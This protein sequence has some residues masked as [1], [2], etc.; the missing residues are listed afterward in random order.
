MENN[1]TSIKFLMRL[2]QRICNENLSKQDCI[3]SGIVDQVNSDGTVNVHIP[4]DNVIFTGIPNQC[5]FGLNPGDTV[6]LIKER[7]RASNMWVIA[8]CGESYVDVEQ[9]SDDYLE[10]EVISLGNSKQDK[11]TAGTGISIVNNVISAT[12]GGGAQ[13]QLYSPIITGGFNQ[14]SWANN[15]SNGDFDVTIV[16]DA[17]GQPVTSPLSITPDMSGEIL[18]VV[19]SSNNFRSAIEQVELEYMSANSLVSMTNYSGSE[20]Q[21]C[22]GFYIYPSTTVADYCT[23]LAD[24]S[25]Y[26]SIGTVEGLQKRWFYQYIDIGNNNLDTKITFNEP[27]TIEQLSFKI[28]ARPYD[29]TPPCFERPG[30]TSTHDVSTAISTLSISWL[31]NGD[32][33]AEKQTTAPTT[34]PFQVLIQLQPQDYISVQTGDELTFVVNVTY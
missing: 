12:G 13:P 19:A 20:T 14:I 25:N 30:A 32:V 17:N 29:G 22:L 23:V 1:N 7:G 4:P 16:A 28:V 21:A 9:S 3:T 10:Q 18:T 11:L 6:K 26:N 8:K 27:Q 33:V 5:P 2:I 34:Y 15:P 31:L 24:G